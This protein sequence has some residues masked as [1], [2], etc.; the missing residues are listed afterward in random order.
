MA[1]GTETRSNTGDISYTAGQDIRFASLVTSLGS[2]YLAAGNVIVGGSID[3]FGLIDITGNSLSMDM[4]RTQNNLSLALTGDLDL[5]VLDVARQLDL[6]AG[7]QAR[8]GTFTVGGAADVNVG[9]G[10]SGQTMQLGSGNIKAGGELNYATINS[11]NL[12]INAG[13]MTFDSLT[14]PTVTANTGG[15]IAMG[16]VNVP[17]A[18]FTAGGAIVDNNS[19]LNVNTLTMS[20]GR[21]IGS[22]AKPINLNT[23]TINR[24][25]S[26]GDIYII[27]NSP[28]LSSLGLISAAG[29]FDITVPDGGFRNGNGGAVNLQAGASSRLYVHDTVGTWGGDNPITIQVRDGQM[30][31]EAY[32]RFVDPANPGRPWMVFEG[33]LPD[34]S[35]FYQGE[36]EIPGLVILNGRVIA[37]GSDILRELYRT[38]AYEVNNPE[39]KSKQGIFGSP[40]F[41]TGLTMVNEPVEMNMLAYLIESQFEIIREGF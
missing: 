31:I 19:R 23:P 17:T 21:D 3:S 15:N 4:L 22:S 10:L 26:G 33:S 25:T 34:D 29:G 12:I 32:N 40:L 6:D 14:A 27:Q 5:D 38:Q 28:G 18:N 20:A 35:V 39:L 7:G 36:T 37:G 24:I 9:G 41:I 13:S 16:T 2:V 1:D 11:G 30:T 8:I